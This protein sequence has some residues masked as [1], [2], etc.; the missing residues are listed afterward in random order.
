MISANGIEPGT[1]GFE[2]FLQL[3]VADSLAA[4]DETATFQNRSVL[5][6]D[7]SELGLRPY[8]FASLVQRLN[9][10]GELYKTL[11]DDEDTIG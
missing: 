10:A 9:T 4:L 11:T 5:L 3:P 6:S 7:P 8:S 1:V 2:H